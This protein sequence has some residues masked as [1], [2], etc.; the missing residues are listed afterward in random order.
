MKVRT[1]VAKVVGV[2]AGFALRPR[3]LTVVVVVAAPLVVTGA[4][5]RDGEVLVLNA[6]GIGIAALTAGRVRGS[7]GAGASEVGRRHGQRSS[8]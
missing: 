1:R 3:R 4:L 8:E 2:A 6:V 7:A 5:T